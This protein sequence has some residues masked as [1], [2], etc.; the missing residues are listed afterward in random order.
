MGI[1]NHLL[2]HRKSFSLFYKP[3]FDCAVGAING[4]LGQWVGFNRQYEKLLAQEGQFK[5]SF[6]NLLQV[7]TAEEP[8]MSLDVLKPAFT[9]LLAVAFETATL[10]QAKKTDRLQKDLSET[11]KELASVLAA[12]TSEDRATLICLAEEQKNHIQE[13]RKREKTVEINH[14]E[15][16]EIQ[17]KNPRILRSFSAGLVGAEQWREEL[18]SKLVEVELIVKRAKQEVTALKNDLGH[19]DNLLIKISAFEE[20]LDGNEVSPE[21]VREQLS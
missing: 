6:R 11:Y 7:K 16:L 4:K 18:Q 2:S 14:A 21:S 17:A 1:E 8:S 3:R 19:L 9:K 5:S 20:V 12:K 10:A 13:V 15:S